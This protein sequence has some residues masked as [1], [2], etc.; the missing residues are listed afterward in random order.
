MQIL[1]ERVIQVGEPL[2]NVSERLSRLDYKDKST[3][4]SPTRYDVV[5]LLRTIDGQE[6]LQECAMDGL[7]A[8]GPLF[9]MC[10]HL[11]VPMTL[12]RNPEEFAEKVH[13]TPANQAFKEDPSLRRMQEFILNSITRH[14][15]PVSGGGPSGT[16]PMMKT[17]RTLLQAREGQ[18]TPRRP[19]RSTWQNE[20]QRW[21]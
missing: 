19:R 15:K 16:C 13:R 17:K 3:S 4:N 20:G 12:M 1:S 9:M 10:I 21:T 18:S 8:V 7:N 6:Q 11:L 2:G 5:S 14:R